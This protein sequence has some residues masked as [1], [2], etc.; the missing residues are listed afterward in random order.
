MERWNFHN[1][2]ARPLA[3]I[4]QNHIGNQHIT[5]DEIE[6]SEFVNTMFSVMVTKAR[7]IRDITEL[8]DIVAFFNLC[9]KYEN[10]PA[11]L[12]PRE[13]AIKMFD[14]FKKLINS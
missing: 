12:I 11:S 9:I 13:N 1:Y 8:K 7:Q 3:D 2:I 14:A 4:T 5:A 6:A 10:S